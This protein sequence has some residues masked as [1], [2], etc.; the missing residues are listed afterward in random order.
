M[1]PFPQDQLDAL[2]P[3]GMVSTVQDGGNW[4]VLIEH[5]RLPAGCTPDNVDVL[6]QLQPRGQYATSLLF[7]RQV[8]SPKKVNWHAKARVADR[9]WEIY[10]HKGVPASRPLLSILVAHL[11]ALRPE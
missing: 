5:C 2:K 4:Y 9:N 1:S 10:S 7:A 11:A 6:L 3:F 8:E